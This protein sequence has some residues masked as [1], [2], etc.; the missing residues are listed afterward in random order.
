MKTRCIIKHRDYPG[1][2]VLYDRA[3]DLCLT[4]STINNDFWWKIIYAR[5]VCHVNFESIAFLVI[6]TSQEHEIGT[7]VQP[8]RMWEVQPELLLF[9]T[10]GF[11]VESRFE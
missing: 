4:G 5:L 3:N 7:R 8:F 9:H 6:P 1:P 10:Q 2:I 11:A